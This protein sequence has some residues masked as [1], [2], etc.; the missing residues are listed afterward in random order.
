[1]RER[2]GQPGRLNHRLDAEDRHR[3]AVQH[4]PVRDILRGEKLLPSLLAHVRLQRGM[5][6]IAYNVPRRRR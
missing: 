1:M 6:V 5:V 3:S 2:F 4:H